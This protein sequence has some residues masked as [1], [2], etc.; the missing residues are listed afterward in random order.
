M[1]L[2]I[3]PVAQVATTGGGY[4]VGYV[5]FS[6]GTLWMRTRRTSYWQDDAKFGTSD[7]IT[8][9]LDFEAHTVA[10]RKNNKAVGRP[11]K[12]ARGE[13]FHFA[14]DSYYKGDAVTLLELW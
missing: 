10:F 13:A 12:I 9:C 4:E 5:Y 14:F 7:A 2:G 3:V 1:G 11:Q 8:V 6:D